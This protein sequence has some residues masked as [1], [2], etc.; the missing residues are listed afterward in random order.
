MEAAKEGEAG[1]LAE[2]LLGDGDIANMSWGR[3]DELEEVLAAEHQRDH[4]GHRRRQRQHVGM[5]LFPSMVAHT[6]GRVRLGFSLMAAVA[7][8]DGSKDIRANSRILNWK[9]DG[10][11]RWLGAGALGPLLLDGCSRRPRRRQGH[12]S[13]L[14][15]LT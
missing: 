6:D 3:E 7:V 4:T 15:E 13:Q 1:G 11:H 5:V 9:S 8:R 2:T 10:P 14:P 12:Q